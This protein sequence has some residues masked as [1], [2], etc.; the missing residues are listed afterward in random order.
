MRDAY[1]R[2][3]TGARLRLVSMISEVSPLYLLPRSLEP[4]RAAWFEMFRFGVE[5]A[6]QCY[7]RLVQSLAGAAQQT[8]VASRAQPV[9]F[10]NLYTPALADAWTFV[11]VMCR[12]RE[13]LISPPHGVRFSRPSNEPPETAKELFCRVTMHVNKMRNQYQHIDSHG[14]NR[15]RRAQ[16]VFGTLVWVAATERPNSFLSCAWTPAPR[17]TEKAMEVPL[18]RAARQGKEAIDL[19]GLVIDDLAMPITD[20]HRTLR[21]VVQECEGML[22]DLKDP[23]YTAPMV[24]IQQPLI[25]IDESV[26][27][28]P[29][30]F[31]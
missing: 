12:I 24:L 20:A 30:R 18:L 6:D 17:S 14:R 7:V 2:A 5:I 15:A 11:D 22:R 19:I 27:R 9:S 23:H 26:R 4:D 29:P 8:S 13:L 25:V 3:S 1:C 21:A 28:T 10:R 31:E 16:S